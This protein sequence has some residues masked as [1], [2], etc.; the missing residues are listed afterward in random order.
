[1]PRIM[2]VGPSVAD[3]LNPVQDILRGVQL[4]Q[5]QAHLEIR[6]RQAELDEQRHHAAM[7]DRERALR[8]RT[9]AQAAERVSFGEMVR[10]VGGDPELGERLSEG[11]RPFYLR[12]LEDQRQQQQMQQFSGM[13]AQRLQDLQEGAAANGLELGQ[14][15]MEIAEQI[16]QALQMAQT[17]QDA[18]AALTAVNR[19]RTGYARR[20]DEEQQYPKAI[21][22]SQAM[23]DGLE[24]LVGGDPEAEEVLGAA[25]QALLLGGTMRGLPPRDVTRAVWSAIRTGQ[26]P[27]GLASLAQAAPQ[28]TPMERLQ[29]VDFGDA[30]AHQELK[31][32]FSNLRH[33]RGG[34][35]TAA[36]LRGLGEKYGMGPQELRAILPL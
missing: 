35:L 33:A 10:A 25:R 9:Q 32:E 23:I 14:E 36:D 18:E 8:E 26:L 24:Q 16:Q 31:Q 6:Q 5:Q 4:G 3:D 13:A 2:Q 12:F 22:K 34:K 30:F 11:A 28:G 17:P 20:V 15:E 29:A 21:Q 27:E 7:A 1:M 19:L